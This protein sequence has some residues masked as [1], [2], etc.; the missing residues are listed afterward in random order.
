MID[1]N[2]IQVEAK[3][4]FH[5]GLERI[6]NK[7][8]LLFQNRTVKQVKVQWKHLSLEEASW[9]LESNIQEAYPKSYFKMMKWK[10]KIASL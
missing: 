5:V 4:E 8:E 9:K 10:N 6:L 7:R 2:V 3:G 1:W